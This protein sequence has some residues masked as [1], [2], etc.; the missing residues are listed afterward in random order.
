MHP[1]SEQSIFDDHIS[2]PWYRG[3]KEGFLRLKALVRAITISR[4]KAVVQLPPRVDEIH[5]LDF[6]PS[7]RVAYED[8][9]QTTVK[10]LE[11]AICSGSAKK[12]N[13]NA[14]Q[15]LNVLR[16]ICSHGSLA[17]ASRKSLKSFVTTSQP[18]TPSDF[19]SPRDVERMSSCPN[20]GMDLLEEI[21]EGSPS[22]N[23]HINNINGPRVLC[24]H[25]GAQTPSQDLL[26]IATTRGQCFSSYDTASGSASPFPTSYVSDQSTL[27]SMSTKIKVLT[28]D[29]IKHSTKKK[30]VCT[31]QSPHPPINIS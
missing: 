7:E 30:E 31:H 25:C 22:S 3:D 9:K 27:K 1:Y 10:M 16:F 28:E 11:E 20:C 19:G 15:R 23:L 13:F 14:L 12:S 4:T 18:Q 17:Q 24:P 5:H 21:L 29:L 2:R 6:A 8:A 26:L